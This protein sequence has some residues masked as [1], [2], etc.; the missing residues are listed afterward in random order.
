MILVNL[1]QMMIKMSNTLLVTCKWIAIS[2]KSKE[3][4]RLAPSFKNYLIS[5][6]PKRNGRGKTF[7]Y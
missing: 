3:E 5:T 4:G 1:K 2:K 6:I 7:E